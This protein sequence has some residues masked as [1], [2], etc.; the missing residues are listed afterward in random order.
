VGA[1]G[2]LGT[3]LTGSSDLYADDGRHPQASVNLV[4][5]HDGFTLRDLV[6]YARKHNE[7]NGEGNRDGLDEN[8]SQNCGVEGETQDGA[9]LARRRTVAR[10]LLAT[11]FL[12]QGIP[13]LEMGD[14]LWRTQRGNNNPY[15][16]DSE[17]TWVD[18]SGGADARGMLE[19]VRALAALRRR[20]A[21][22]RRLEFLRGERVGESRGKDVTWLRIDGKEMTGDDWSAPTQAVLAFRLDGD[23]IDGAP[24]HVRVRDDSFLVLMNGEAHA[25]RFVA[26]ARELGPAWRVVVET[27]EAPR[28]GV[29]VRAGESI[30]LAAGSLVALVQADDA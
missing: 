12:A 27:A 1:V 15:C 4:T 16:Q 28:A 19:F 13:M 24:G 8:L 7:A 5:A 21:A 30:E 10:S 9:I 2:D 18:W 29:V 17:L 25:V 26:P 22:F 20:H 6:S 3:R 11:M 14:E 23:A